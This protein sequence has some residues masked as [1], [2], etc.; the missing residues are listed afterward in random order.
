MTEMFSTNRLEFRLLEE[1]DIKY[2][3]LLDGDPIVK[4]FF[5][6]GARSKEEVESMIQRFLNYYKEHGLPC[7]LIFDKDT[8]EFIGRCGFGL[9]E[10]GEVEVGYVLHQKYWGQGYGT[11]ALKVLLVWAEKNIP[12]EYIIAFAP[13]DHIASQRVMEKCG[14]QYYKNDISKGD[15]CKFYKKELK[16]D[17]NSCKFQTSHTIERNN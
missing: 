6:Q 1:Q 3:E 12:N 11:E 15:E 2:L 13:V 14:M 5:P 9:V 10:S 7:F 16:T 17:K 4:K 8:G